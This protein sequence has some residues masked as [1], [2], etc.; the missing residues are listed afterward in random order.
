MF[1]SNAKGYVMSFCQCE[2]KHVVIKEKFANN[3]EDVWYT[4]VFG[5]LTLH[6]SL[7]FTFVIIGWYTLVVHARIKSTQS[8]SSEFSIKIQ[9]AKSPR[10]PGDG[11]SIVYMQYI[12]GHLLCTTNSGKLLLFSR[13]IL[14]F[15]QCNIS[16]AFHNMHY[17]IQSHSEELNGRGKDTKK[18]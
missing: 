7:F 11:N 3:L 18:W 15:F 16:G 8:H 13:H 1:F 17:W 2:R 4:E 9:I 12:E 6:C 10:Y 5:L 14:S